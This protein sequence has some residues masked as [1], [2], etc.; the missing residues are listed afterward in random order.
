MALTE[1][2]VN[3][4]IYTDALRTFD[5][6][7]HFRAQATAKGFPKTKTGMRFFERSDGV[8]VVR[9]YHAG[10]L[11]AEFEFKSGEWSKK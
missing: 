10:T 9:D 8:L 3:V 5:M 1:I 6:V 11:L 7:D 2:E 4:R